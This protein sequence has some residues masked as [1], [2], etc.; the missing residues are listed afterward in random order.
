MGFSSL[1]SLST[2]FTRRTGVSPSVWRRLSE[3]AQ[4]GTSMQA[5]VAESPEG[6]AP[7]YGIKCTDKTSG[8]IQGMDGP[9]QK[10]V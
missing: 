9:F 1:G 8:W 10:H 6:T 2:L 5:G 7:P 3:D 4:E